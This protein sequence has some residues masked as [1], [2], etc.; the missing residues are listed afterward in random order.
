[1]KYKIH[2]IHSHILYGVDD[3]ANSLDMSIDMLRNAYNQGARS[4]ICTSHS[5][6]NMQQYFKNLK[7][8]Q[9]HLTTESIN[10]NLYS[11]CEI[12]CDSDN[13]DSVIAKLNNGSLPTINN[14]KYILVEFFPYA[15][16]DEILYCIK[17][18]LEHNYKIVIAHIERYFGLH[19]DQKWTSI[20]KKLGCH[21]QVNAYSVFDERDLQVKMFAQKLLKEKLV[22]FLGS[23]AH[24]ISHRP[25]MINNGINYIEENCDDD[26][27][28]D[29]CYRNAEN[30]LNIK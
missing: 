22:T 28:Q 24:K 5:D 4:I 27:I 11:G 21:F 26:Y 16:A 6:S 14:T 9:E 10:M 25:Y 20:L 12:Y 15:D 23:D 18:L 2:D 29:V 30:L 3:G 1:M 19:K 17:L 7:S 13:I 8:L